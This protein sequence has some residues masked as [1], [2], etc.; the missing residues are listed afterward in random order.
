MPRLKRSPQQKNDHSQKQLDNLL[1]KYGSF[2]ELDTQQKVSITVDSQ[3]VFS[4]ARKKYYRSYP[5][6]KAICERY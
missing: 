2:E 6:H 4:L 5:R 3:S 1:I